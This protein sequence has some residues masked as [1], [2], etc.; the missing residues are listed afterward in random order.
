[1]A[2]AKGRINID[3]GNKIPSLSS[4]LNSFN[5][6]GGLFAKKNVD[7]MTDDE[8]MR[9][10]FKKCPHKNYVVCS[11]HGQCVQGAVE[12]GGSSSSKGNDYIIL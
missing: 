8:I 1:M 7:E 6:K 3:S 2:V 5:L 12:K 9:I 4:K 11:G 10:Y